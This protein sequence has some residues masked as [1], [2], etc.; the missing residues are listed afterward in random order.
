MSGFRFKLIFYNSDNV[1]ENH[2]KVWNDLAA[3]SIL[4]LNNEL[5][6]II[7][8]QRFSYVYDHLAVMINITTV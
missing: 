4:C 2:N 5:I 3:Q 6:I 7:L 1:Y 8:M